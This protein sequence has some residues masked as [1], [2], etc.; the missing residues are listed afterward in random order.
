MRIFAASFQCESNTFCKRNAGYD[1]FEILRG[2][3]AAEKMAASQVFKDA[4]CELVPGIYASALPAG[5]VEQDAFNQIANEIMQRLEDSETIDGIYLYLHGS[6]YVNGLGSG[7][8]ALVK[9]I[10]EK[11]GN[12]IPIAVALD[13]HANNTPAFIRQVNIVQGFRTAPHT[14]HDMTETRAAKGLIRCIKQ[15]ILPKPVMIKVPVLAADAAITA[16]PPL[17]DMMKQIGEMEK[18]LD[19]FSAAFFNGQPWA[20]FEYVGPSVVMMYHQEVGN[21]LEKAK[22]IAQMFWDGKDKMK[23]GNQAL[24]IPDALAYA[25]KATSKPIFLCDSGDNTT[26]GAEGEGTLMLDAMMKADLK[27][28]LLCAVTAKDIIDRFQH[29]TIGQ[30]VSFRIGDNE[31]ASNMVPITVSGTIKCFGDVTGWSG[32]KAG[33]SM[34]IAIGSIDLVI[35]D[36]RAAFISKKHF[37]SVGVNPDDYDT[38]VVKMGYLFPKL[39]DISEDNIFVLTPGASTNLF[40][41]IAYE[42]IVHP[43]YP[44]DKQFEWRPE[45]LVMG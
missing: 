23:L 21:A 43:V 33:K 36:V 4:G 14:D 39:L 1:D 6:M 42:H 40:E 41:S 34:T 17:S 44:L 24:L 30:V 28:V 8:E 37:E 3:H 38:I 15:G 7:E 16:K 12:Q 13:F 18:D 5:C 22:R 29:S 11:M 31:D 20:D 9:R 45:P 27:N 35:T 19:I 25:K 32:E 2:T 10:R 26:A